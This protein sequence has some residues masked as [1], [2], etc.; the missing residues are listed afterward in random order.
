MAVCVLASVCMCEGL[1]AGRSEQ[2]GFW[3]GLMGQLP[4][5]LELG[6]DTQPVGLLAPVGSS[7]TKSSPF[8]QCPCPRPCGCGCRH[9]DGPSPGGGVSTGQAG[10]PASPWAAGETAR[11]VGGNGIQPTT[12]GGPAHVGLEAWRPRPPS[13]EQGGEATP[14]ASALAR[15]CRLQ[16]LPAQPGQKCLCRAE[17]LPEPPSLSLSSQECPPDGRSF[18]EEQC[19]SFNSRVYNGRTHQWKPLYPGTGALGHPA[20]ALSRR[21]HPLWPPP[22]TT[23]GHALVQ[24]EGRGETG[25]GGFLSK[26][27]SS[28]GN[29]AQ[30]L[31]SPAHG[32]GA[33]SPGPAARGRQVG[34]DVLQRGCCLLLTGLQGLDSE[35]R[36]GTDHAHLRPRR[37]R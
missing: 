24:R 22:G 35:S 2:P 19:I 36:P 8:S 34:S 31:A 4:S 11:V 30:D 16:P 12:A 27:P 15:P 20:G 25:L 1:G 23:G 28:S 37:Y 13:R 29:S 26:V 10:V 6:R 9:A 18:R 14:R 17:F 3:V 32:G 33:G 21:I 7:S 5:R